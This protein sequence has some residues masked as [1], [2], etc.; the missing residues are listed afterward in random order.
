MSKAD[1]RATVVIAA[2]ILVAAALVAA[3]G[4][5]GK[6]VV[7]RPSELTFAKMENGTFQAIVLGDPTKPG[8]Y[9]TRAKLPAGLRIRPHVH[10][11]TRIVYVISGTLYFGYGDR[12]D[13]TKMITLPAGTVFTEPE[14]EPHFTWAK[15]GDVLVHA[16][17]VGPTATRW[18]EPSK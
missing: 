12:F 10:P 1:P 15:D 18:L 6:R 4:T 11:D 13:E 7:V 16:T 17:G 8:P 14:N 3:Q 2:A 5:P 9:A